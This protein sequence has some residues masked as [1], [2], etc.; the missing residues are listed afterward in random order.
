ML[1]RIWQWL[2]GRPVPPLDPSRELPVWFA[3]AARAGRP[4][5]LTWVG[6]DPAGVPL[7]VCD[8]G[9]VLAL[10][11][12]VARFEPDP[13]G[14]LADVPQAREPRT[15]IAVFEF[16]RGVWETDGR[17]VFNL[18]PRQ[19]LDRDPARYRLLAEGPP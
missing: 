17:T 19:F 9:R 16:R 7:L 1:R 14:E 15:V 3:R 10:V 4:R 13:A 11:P 8:G 6:F 5:G 18:T 12:A 2:L